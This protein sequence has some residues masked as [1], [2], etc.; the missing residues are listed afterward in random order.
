MKRKDWVGCAKCGATKEAGKPC[1]RCGRRISRYFAPVSVAE[2]AK[3]TAGHDVPDY[4]RYCGH[5]FM[6]HTN[7]ACPQ[8]GIA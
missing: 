1:P 8:E 3:G 5:P 7:G 2:H 4:C 6:D